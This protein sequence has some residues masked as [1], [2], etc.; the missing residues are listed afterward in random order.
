MYD[1]AFCLQ[2]GNICGNKM[3]EAKQSINLDSEY[4]TISRTSSVVPGR[5]PKRLGCTTGTSRRP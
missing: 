3:Q 2:P 5:H 1:L 4:T